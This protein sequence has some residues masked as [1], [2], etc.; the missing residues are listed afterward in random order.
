[1]MAVMIGS[2]LLSRDLLTI[3]ELVRGDGERIAPYRARLAALARPQASAAALE[4]AFRFEAHTWTTFAHRIRMILRDNGGWM[5]RGDIHSPALNW[6][7]SLF[8][9][10]NQTANL[11]VAT[12]KIEISIAAAPAAQ[13][14]AKVKEI[15]A[16]KTSQLAWPWYSK[17]RN[18][19]GKA[20]FEDIATFP[21][22]AARMHDL[23]ALERMTSLQIA[24]AELGGAAMPRQPRRS[25]RE[26]ARSPIPIPT[27]ANPSPLI[28]RS[29]CCRSSRGRRVALA[30]T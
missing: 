28:R 2:R 13:F 5:L 10:P 20:N 30:M 12:A 14:D 29:A 3:S 15:D 27:P 8:A 18:P 16:A 7:E 4:P 19:V 1:M 9:L 24:L 26:R 25:S 6:A 22:Y 17:L 23:Q 11:V 21:P